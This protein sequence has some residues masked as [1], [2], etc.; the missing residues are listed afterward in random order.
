[1]KRFI[2]LIALLWAVSALNAQN[3]LI[4]NLK[5]EKENFYEIIKGDKPVIV[6]FW[7]TWCKPCVMELEALK[8]IKSEWEGKIRIIAISIDDS[9]SKGKVLSFVKGKNFPF[10]VYLD[11]NHALYKSL[12]ITSTPFSLI[13]K[14]GEK[15]YMHSGYNPGDEEYI[16][17]EAFKY[18]KDKK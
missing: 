5:G 4:E 16:I 14:D 15:V 17:E 7:A 8:E 12:N 11:T 6:S 3:V 9:R 10:E 2:V 1:M 18:I 13:F